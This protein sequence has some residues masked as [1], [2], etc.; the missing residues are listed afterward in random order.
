MNNGSKITRID[1]RFPVNVLATTV[2]N[3]G[4]SILIALNK[5]TKAIHTNK[6]IIVANNVMNIFKNVIRAFRSLESLAAGATARLA[7]LAYQNKAAF[8]YT[9][10]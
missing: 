8:I 7:F 2:R 6:G 4:I 9:R 10:E 5:L 1:S 3:V